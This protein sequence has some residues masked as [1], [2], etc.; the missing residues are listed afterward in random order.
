MKPKRKNP[1]EMLLER[2][3]SFVYEIENP[4]T[5]TSKWLSRDN[6]YTISDFVEWT[7]EAEKINCDV[8]IFADDFDICI[9]FIKRP[10]IPREWE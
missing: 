2:I 3:K 9:L 4:E 8:H 5:E 7:D 1:Y 6:I 10:N